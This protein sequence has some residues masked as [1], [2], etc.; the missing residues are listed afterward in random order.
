MRKF[1]LLGGVLGLLAS[2]PALAAN[3]TTCIRHNDIWNF[4]S[5]GDRMMVLENFRHQKVLVTLAGTCDNTQFVDS[6]RVKSF[7]GFNLSCVERGDEIL[8]HEAG[9]RG[10]C[11]IL[12]V[13]NYSGDME[14][15][16]GRHHGNP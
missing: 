14:R 11:T 3:D 9:M 4:H 12:S 8:T 6:I 7:G 10:R 1:F 2:A 13:Q 16:D 5:A 15:G